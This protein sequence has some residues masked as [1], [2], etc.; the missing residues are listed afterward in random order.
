M[1][2]V[3]IFCHLDSHNTIIIHSLS[4]NS[5]DEDESVTSFG[6]AVF[7]EMLTSSTWIT[8]PAIN[9]VLVNPLEYL[10]SET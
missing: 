1:S 9:V 3:N 5:T 10:K 6:G 2:N 8:F 7:L 4:I